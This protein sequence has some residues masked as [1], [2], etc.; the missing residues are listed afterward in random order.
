MRKILSLLMSLAASW[1]FSVAPAAAATRP[2][3]VFIFSDDHAYQSISAY[4]GP[5]GPS[6]PDAKH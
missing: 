6:G 4:G 2:N 3:I 1:W 5:V